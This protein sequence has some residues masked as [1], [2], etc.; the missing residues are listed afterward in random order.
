MPEMNCCPEF[1][2]K[3]SIINNPMIF[4]QA[5]GRMGDKEKKEIANAVFKY[6][7]WCGKLLKEKK[8]Q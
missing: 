5:T 7:P 3:I 2:K 1:E 8:M 6:C 4:M